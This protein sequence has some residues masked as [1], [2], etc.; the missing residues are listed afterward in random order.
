MTRRRDNLS[1]A[2]L[3]AGHLPGL[4]L[5]AEKVAHSFMKG[6]HGRRRVGTGE[7]F[8]QFRPYQPGDSSRDIDWRQTAKRE[9]AF[10]RQT[11]WEAA[12]TAWLYR[13]ASE[14]MNFSSAQDLPSKKDYAEILLLALGM[15]LLNGGEQV[16]L[17]GTDLAPQSGYASSQRIFEMLPA[18]IGLTDSGRPV[19]ARSQAVLISDFYFPLPE[20]AS[21]CERLAARNVKGLLVQIFDPAEQTLPYTGRVRFQDAENTAAEP[22]VIP[23]VEAVRGE[24]ER[25][26]SAHQE[27]LAALAQNLGWKFEKFTTA[28]KPE[29]ALTQLYNDLSVRI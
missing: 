7:A 25:K 27:S 9:D 3:L 2:G 5:E 1:Q 23:H 16:G 18:Q 26:F 11:E 14:S 28:T 4:L 20:L 10:V 13:D 8:W 6:I 29:A 12:Q 21:F 22:L 24:Y 17:L 15:V 19:T